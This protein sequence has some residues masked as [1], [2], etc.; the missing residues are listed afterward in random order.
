MECPIILTDVVIMPY[1]LLKFLQDSLGHGLRCINA[2][3]MISPGDPHQTTAT[4]R[5]LKLPGIFSTE[6]AVALAPKDQGGLLV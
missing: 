3:R 4:D 2:R 6:R 1:I 5:S